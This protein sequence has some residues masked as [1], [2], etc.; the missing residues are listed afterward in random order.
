MKFIELCQGILPDAFDYFSGSVLQFLCKGTTVS[1]Q[2][3]CQLTFEFKSH[4]KA[5]ITCSG[6]MKLADA[7]VLL[8]K[9]KIHRLYIVDQSM[10]PIGVVTMSDIVQSFIAG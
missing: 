3:P 5:P 2:P 10:H 7:V 8:A 9:E 6:D 4:P 1:C